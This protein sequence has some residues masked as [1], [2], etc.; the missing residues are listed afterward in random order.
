VR[1]WIGFV[2]VDSNNNTDHL[3]QFTHKAGVGKAKSSF[4]QLI[5]LLCSWVVWNERNNRLFNNIVT[6]VPRL[7]DKVKLLSLGWLKAKNAMLVFGT[8]RWW[9]S[10]L[11]CLGIG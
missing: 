8:Q 7:L 11:D 4:M 1:D 3:V 9:S 6:I 2:G 5:W 10:P